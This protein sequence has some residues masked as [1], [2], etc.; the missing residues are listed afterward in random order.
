MMLLP[1]PDAPAGFC[2][3]V[4]VA[5]KLPAGADPNVFCDT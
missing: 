3:N 1:N 2:P 5:P 4:F